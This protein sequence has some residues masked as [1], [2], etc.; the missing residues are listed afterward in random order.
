MAS[1]HSGSAVDDCFGNMRLQ[2]F[3]DDMAVL[4]S[5]PHGQ[6]PGGV[7]NCLP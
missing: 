6:E 5:N 4:S 3:V 1:S 7:E 2:L